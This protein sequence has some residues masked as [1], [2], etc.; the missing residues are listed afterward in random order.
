[1]SEKDKKEKG[2]NFEKFRKY[3]LGKLENINLITFTLSGYGFMIF[4]IFSAFLLVLLLSFKNI[5]FQKFMELFI[6]F[7]IINL[8]LS[9]LTNSY[10]Q[11]N[12]IS[13]NSRKDY[14]NL[15]KIF[16]VS[17]CLN[18]FG[19]LLSSIIEYTKLE[20]N[21]F[22]SYLFL[23]GLTYFLLGIIKLFLFI[24]TKK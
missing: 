13:K 23:F 22:E 8:S 20:H 2:N 14:F 16:L 10:S 12:N 15:S 3:I 7:L 21:D 11:N 24:Y 4:L 1:M 9:I 18:L 5:N 6:T 17:F 19:L